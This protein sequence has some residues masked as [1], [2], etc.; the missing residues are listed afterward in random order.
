MKPF[1]TSARRAVLLVPSVILLM[2]AGGTFAVAQSARDAFNL[3]NTIMRAAVIER[4]QAEWRKLPHYELV[5]I[6]QRLQQEGGSTRDLIERGVTPG[7]PRL[8]GL[9]VGC[10]SA[11]AS[12]CHSKRR[13]C[14][15]QREKLWSCRMFP[16][17]PRSTAPGQSPP[18]PASFVLIGTVPERIGTLYQL[19]IRV[20]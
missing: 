3:F 20:S 15:L 7:D 19:Y 14:H 4:I 10:G 6:E 11:T 16:L 2:L 17:D 5:C 8:S 12:T 1:H 9:R 18:L 13:D